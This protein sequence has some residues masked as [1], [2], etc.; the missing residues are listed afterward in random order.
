MLRGWR[1]GGTA[2][3]KEKKLSGA[4]I[5]SAMEVF[6]WQVY[7]TFAAFFAASF[8]G[9]QDNKSFIQTLVVYAVGF[10][11]RP[12]GSLIFGGIADV[13][14]RRA[15][16]LATSATA[17]VGTVLVATAPTHEQIGVGAAII[18][19]TARIIQGLAHG[20]EQPA[21]GAYMAEQ[22]SL[23]NRG[24]LSSY[25]YVSVMVGNIV[26]TLLAALI[27]A[28][29]S[30]EDISSWVWRIPFIVGGLGSMMALYSVWR[31]RETEV[32]EAE[33][34][35]PPLA[36]QM[37][38]SWRPALQIIMLTWGL[39]V[40]FQ[41]WAVIA[42]FHIQVLHANPNHV[43]WT[44]VAANVVTAIALPLWGSLSDV[45]GRKPILYIG[46]GGLVVSAYPLMEFLDGSW[47]HM[48]VAMTTSMV[49]LAGPLAIL[50][51]L[52]AELVPTSIRTIGVG[53]A[54]AISTAIFGGTV[55][56]LQAWIGSQRHPQQFGIYVS[57]AC[58]ISL[59]VVLR[60]P[61]TK[62]RDLAEVPE[63]SRARN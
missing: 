62:H 45:I 11:A 21:A 36:R 26:A 38:K 60:I 52:M 33:T 53:L 28:V 34:S 30:K 19:V 29:F 17:F 47:Q 4:L 49:L 55:P 9:N 31:L 16:L 44:A 20:G 5:G 37:A 43:M 41:N 7:S 6:D 14:G 48:L 54:Y 63:D 15:S 23:K 24:R 58:L 50:P 27:T 18:L 57:L 25:V 39:T 61:E 56:A 46:L 42:G 40:A 32:F 1:I 35:K 59:L 51:G 12:I 3:K 8:F 10:V 22:S 13:R 2:A